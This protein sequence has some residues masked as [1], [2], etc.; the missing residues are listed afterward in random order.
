MVPVSAEEPSTEAIAKNWPNFR[1]PWGLGVAGTPQA[2]LNW[3]ATKQAG[4]LWKAPVPLPGQNSPVV[5]N[6]RVFLSG[7]DGKRQEVYCFDAAKGTLLWKQPVSTPES[8][9]APPPQVAEECGYAAPTLATNGKQVCVI[10]ASGDVAAF[11]F[12]GKQLWARNLGPF[13]NNYGHASSLILHQGRLLVQADQGYSADEGKSALVALEA[14][15]G[16]TLWRT[17]RPVPNGWSSPILINT[18]RRVEVVLAGNPWL[19]GYDPVSGSELW[20]ASCLG[21]EVAPS[22]AFANGLIFAANL[23]AGLTAIRADGQGEIPSDKF[24]WTASDGIPDTVSP[25]AT[26]DYVFLV[27]SEGLV[28][29]YDAAKGTKLWE[30]DLGAPV[31]AS[32]IL[33]GNNV[34]LLDTAGVMHIF[35]A[36][37]QFRGVGTGRLGEE[38][39]ATPA[40]VGGR[41]FIR[42]ARNLFC[43]GT[44]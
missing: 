10:F 4:V 32:P 39:H 12:A 7:S 27:T 13:E 42:G 37:P 28:T 2:P 44:A 21:G 43:I 31:T 34:Y 6:D 26:K 36:A 17:A 19:I 30:H 16:K 40:F 9:K 5:W 15:T 38:A 1:G 24:V 23:G 20:R 41:I 33:V 25:L 8:Q 29:C 11:D 22:P 35:E 14:A 3:D 18:G